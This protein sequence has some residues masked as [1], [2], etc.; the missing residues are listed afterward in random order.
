MW[1][2]TLDRTIQTA[3]RARVELG[4]LA[5]GEITR[6]RALAEIN[7][8]IYDGCTYEQV[9]EMDPDGFEARSRDKLNYK[10]PQGESYKD[11][12]DRV[13][14]VIFELERQEQPVLVVAHQAVIRCL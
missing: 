11:V 1:C 2:S 3:G 10:Y 4:D 13:E 5:L 7:A 9:Q 6:W 12:I 8:G 14:R